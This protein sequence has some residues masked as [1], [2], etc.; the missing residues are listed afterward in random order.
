MKTETAALS[1]S[2]TAI[3]RYI[4]GS[5]IGKTIRILQYHY[6]SVFHLSKLT[7]H[8]FNLFL[9][10]NVGDDDFVSF[11]KMFSMHNTQL[12]KYKSTGKP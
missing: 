7:G 5:R 2:E 8:V 10:Y 9:G 3:P 12:R 6:V 1:K 4:D 11:S